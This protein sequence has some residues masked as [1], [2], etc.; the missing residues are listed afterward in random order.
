[1]NFPKLIIYINWFLIFLTKIYLHY[2]FSQKFYYKNN[3]LT[4]L[5]IFNKNQICILKGSST[6]FLIFNAI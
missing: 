6:A 4:N 1:M 5:Q 2:T 3:N